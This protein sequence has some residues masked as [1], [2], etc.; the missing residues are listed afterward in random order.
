ML[1][2][3]ITQRESV[4][5]P[6]LVEALLMSIS[7]EILRESDMRASST[8]GSAV[9][10]LGGLIL[11]D[12]L[13]SAGIISPIM[14]IVVAIS[15]ISGLVFTSVELSSCIR[16]FRFLL[17]FLGT[18]L[19]IYGIILGLIY[20]LIKLASINSFG[21]PYTTPF[22]PIIFSELRDSFIKKEGDKYRKRNSILTKNIIRGRDL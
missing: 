17:M 13:V 12:A 21:Y 2:N 14:I 8:I 22:G 19:G 4:P 3:F 9:S 20:L 18:F 6:A 16:F 7:F 5:F 15:A 11:G 1:L 10:I